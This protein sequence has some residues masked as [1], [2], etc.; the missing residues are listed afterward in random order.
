MEPLSRAPG[1]SAGMLDRC[2]ESPVACAWGSVQQFTHTPEADP[3]RFH[4]SFFFDINAQTV[5]DEGGIIRGPLT[6]REPV[7]VFA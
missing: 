4:R 5:E 6:G 2:G 3:G 1:A 7:E